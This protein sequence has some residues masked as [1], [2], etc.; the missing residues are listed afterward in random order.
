M[1]KIRIMKRDIAKLKKLETAVRRKQRRILRVHNIEQPFNFK[2]ITDIKSGSRQELNNY[3]K[4]LEK[5]TA[6]KSHRYKRINDEVSVPY[7]EYKQY[8]RNLKAANKQRK[9]MREAVNKILKVPTGKMSAYDYFQGILRNPKMEFTA[10]LSADLTRIHDYYDWKRKYSSIM[11]YADKNFSAKSVKQMKTNYIHAI[12]NPERGLMSGHNKREVKLLANRIK[13]MNNFQFYAMYLSEEN[14]DFT[15]IYEYD[16]REAM[17]NLVNSAID[18]SYKGAY[19]KN[20]K[21]FK[22][23]KKK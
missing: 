2:S 6:Y 5:F 9:T 4:R 19:G 15:Y 11:R 12:L 22:K 20:F 17:V 7:N 10:P 23:S 3:Y 14:L 1:A 16:D 18:L 21:S 8:E 13:R